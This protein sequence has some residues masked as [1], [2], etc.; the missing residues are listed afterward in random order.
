[1]TTGVLNGFTLTQPS[2]Q[3]QPVQ[4]ESAAGGLCGAETP[5]GHGILVWPSSGGIHYAIVDS[6]RD[7]VVDDVV[8][9][10]NIQTAVATGNG[11][12]D[13]SVFVINGSLYILAHAQTATVGTTKLY[14][15]DNPNA[16]TSWA[17]RNTLSSIDTTGI[18][19]GSPHSIGIPLELPS[20]R[21]VLFCEGWEEGFSAS[22]SNAVR[23]WYSDDEGATFTPVLQYEHYSTGIPTVSFVSTQTA[24]HPSTGYLYASSG[25]GAGGVEYPL[26][27]WESQNAGESW[28]IVDSS[29]DF[30][31][32]PLLSPF[33]SNGSTLFAQGGGGGGGG[34]WGAD[35]FKLS[36]SAAVMTNWVDSGVF[37]SLDGTQDYETRKAI[38]TSAGVFYFWLDKVSFMGAGWYVGFVGWTG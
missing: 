20:G 21:W 27:W 8:P 3:A 5:D 17:L 6:V 28:A 26:A 9:A 7:F 12:H 2:V 37:Y 22:Y 4:D 25:S 36:G 13:T 24:A 35:M 11:V 31:D 18:R 14:K 30:Y 29:L 16:P 34:P 23:A 10:A 33:L 15:A 32:D 38:I 19:V 1:M